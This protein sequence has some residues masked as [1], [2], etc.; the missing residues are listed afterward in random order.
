VETL[1]QLLDLLLPHWPFVAAVLVLML[2]GTVSNKRIFTEAEAKV[3]RRTQW[4][5]WWARKTLPLHPV[6]SGI[7][8]GIVWKLPEAGVD[9][10]VERAA[11][12][13][14]AGA[15]SVFAYELLKGLAKKRGLDLDL[16]GDTPSKP[17]ANPGA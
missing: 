8:L 14:L 1:K 6:V 2:V 7:V 11:Y 15:C 4:F 10:L 12:F 17:P 5:F 9:T 13:G 3:K 16:P